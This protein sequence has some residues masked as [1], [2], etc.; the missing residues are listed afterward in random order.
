MARKKLLIGNWKLNHTQ[1]SAADFVSAVLPRIDHSIIDLAI[2]PTAVMLGFLAQKLSGHRLALAAQNVFYADNG[3][4]TGEWSAGQLAELNITYCIVGHSERRK[5]FLEND[6]IVS[7]KMDACL[8]SCISP[9]V[10]VGESLEER[11]HG[12]TKAVITKQVTEVLQGKR[13]DNEVIFAYEPIWAIGTGKTATAEQ[14][15]EIHQVI[16]S[17]MVAHG[18]EAWANKSR[19]LYGGSVTAANI[20]EICSMPDI[21]GALVGGASLQV[22]SFLAMVEELQGVEKA[23]LQ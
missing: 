5:L 18:Q 22:A 11:E 16:R 14:A 13:L 12:Q 21:D 23:L 15:Q 9:V 17:L 3:A 20:K 10:C 8:R 1:K 7:K 2:A 19:I 6:E 4:Y